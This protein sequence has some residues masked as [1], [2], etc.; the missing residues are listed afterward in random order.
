MDAKNKAIIDVNRFVLI[1]NLHYII[2]FRRYQGILAYMVDW[3]SFNESEVHLN[4]KRFDLMR[5]E[6]GISKST[7]NKYLREMVKIGLVKRFARGNSYVVHPLYAFKGKRFAIKTVMANNNF[8]NMVS[9]EKEYHNLIS[10]Y[11]ES[12]RVY[13]AR[14]AN[15]KKDAKL[16]KIR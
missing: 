9:V 4:I 15:K 2:E 6:L 13:K 3:M 16:V 10:S 14:A 1:S 12:R 8:M 5:G 11:E 7:M